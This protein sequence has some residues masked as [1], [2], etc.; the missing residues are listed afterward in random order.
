MTHGPMTEADTAA[1]RLRSTLA[2]LRIALRGSGPSQSGLA[3]AALE[4][5][6]DKGLAHDHIRLAGTGWLARVPKQSQ[7]DLPPE[8]N[9]AYQAACSRRAGAGG[10]VPRLHAVLPPG[11]GLAQGAL[12]V[13]EIAGRP[14]RL[15]HDLPA[16]ARALASIHALPA[17]AVAVPLLAPADPLAAMQDE[18]A[19]QGAYLAEAR[20]DP[21][22]RARIEDGIAALRTLCAAPARPATCLISFDAHPGNFLI[23]ADG[24]AVLVDLEKGR[25]GAP[26]LDLAHATNYTS[27]TWDLDSHAVLSVDE[28]AGFYAAWSAVPGVPAAAAWHWPLRRAMWLWAVT[29]CAKWRVLSAAPKCHAAQGEDWSAEASDDALIAHVRARVDHYLSP[30]VVARCLEEF[31]ALE[32][33]C[34]G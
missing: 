30:S 25:Y 33:S 21:A 13:E 31:A 28:I 5:M 24:S 7:M 12:I 26:S 18:V 15:P 9:L 22:T 20:L 2:G 17:P 3:H 27:T 4:P 32:R 10:H 34:A 1:P 16:I 23:R 19:G 11:E 6:R 8:Q 14:A 29:W